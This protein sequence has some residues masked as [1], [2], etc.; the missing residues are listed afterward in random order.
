MLRQSSLKGIYGG[1]LL[2]FLAML[3]AGPANATSVTIP[4]DPIN[5]YLLTNDDGGAG[6]SLAIDLN[7]YGFFAGDTILLEQL[8][9][10][11][12]GVN[13]TDTATAMIGVFSSTSILL[14]S[15]NLNRVLG[16]LDAGDDVTTS[17]TWFGDI[18][19]NIPEDFSITSTVITIPVGAQY[20]FVAASDS[21]Y[22]DNTDPDGDFAVRISSYTATSVP[23]PATLLLLGVALVGLAGLGRKVRK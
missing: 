10:F 22:Q 15:D 6:D 23:E 3:F 9:D 2:L 14:S 1:I 8:G 21:L 19:T 12:R 16:A 7:S 5:T 17:N 11:Q 20:L 18:S 13:F 4:I